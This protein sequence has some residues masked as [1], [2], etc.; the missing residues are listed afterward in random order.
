MNPAIQ[1]LLTIAIGVGG[2][3]SYF[4]FSNQVLDNLVPM[5]L[6]IYGSWPS[7][8]EAKF[9]RSK[10]HLFLNLQKKTDAKTLAVSR[11]AKISHSKIIFKTL[12]I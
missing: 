6:S 1:G 9:S 3:L 5:H 10:V 2:C 12:S 11:H 4:Y 7:F 8:L